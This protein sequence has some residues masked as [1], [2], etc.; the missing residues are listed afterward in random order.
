MGIVARR[1]EW[2]LE[3]SRVQVDKEMVA[4]PV[5]R[6]G[7]LGVRFDMAPGIPESARAVLERSAH[8]CPVSNSLA[9]DVKLDVT[10][11]WR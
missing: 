11:D 9:P 1:H 4:D 8:T 2:P 5:R 3:G 10:F 6:V 7:R